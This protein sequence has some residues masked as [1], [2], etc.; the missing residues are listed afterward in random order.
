[1]SAYLSVSA[2]RDFCKMRGLPHDQFDDEALAALLLR[3]SELLDE[4]CAF[5]G[6]KARSDQLRAW[7]RRNVS[8]ESGVAITDVP[9]VVLSAVIHLAL[10]LGDDEKEAARNLGL[11][12][13]IAV[14]RIGEIQ[15]R[16]ATDNHQLPPLLRPLWPLMRASQPI[17][18]VRS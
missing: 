13:G 5:R 8:D 1:M 2:A 6:L 7:P 12:G 18:V 3:A 11:T 9:A 16:Y 4:I 15:V 10:Q 17:Y 14:E